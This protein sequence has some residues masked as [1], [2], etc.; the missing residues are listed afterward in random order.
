[1][2]ENTLVL[3]VVTKVCC[4]IANAL[5]VESQHQSETPTITSRFHRARASLLLLLLQDSVLLLSITKALSA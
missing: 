5:R 3:S 4:N 2:Q 1:V